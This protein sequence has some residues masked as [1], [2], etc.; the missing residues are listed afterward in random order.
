[1]LPLP[2]VEIQENKD[3]NRT[4]LPFR[5]PLHRL[6]LKFKKTRIETK[7]EEERKT[8]L[9]KRL[10]KSKKTRIET[11]LTHSYFM[12]CCC[13]EIQENK[14][15]N[16]RKTAVIACRR[17]SRWNPRKQGLKHMYMRLSL[18]PSLPCWNPRKQGLKRRLICGHFHAPPC[19]NPRK[20]G[21]KRSHILRFFCRHF[22]VEI[23]E[24]K[25]WNVVWRTSCCHLKLGWNPRKQGLKQFPLIQL[26]SQRNL[27][28]IQENKD[29]NDRHLSC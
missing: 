21:L 7:M 20:Q 14:D 8:L 26:L 12:S 28:E 13:V 29:W 9:K 5:L 18:V 6:R 24:N 4:I 1:M 16:F 25:D 2:L 23:Q 3:W 10:L 15:W 22:A 11:H 19:W 17:Q 27:V